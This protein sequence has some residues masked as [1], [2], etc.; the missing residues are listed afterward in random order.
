[1]KY[2]GHK[3]NLRKNKQNLGRSVLY[4]IAMEELV[5]NAEEVI[6]IKTINGRNDEKL[7]KLAV[8]VKDKEGEY[9]AH[10]I[11]RLTPPASNEGYL[12]KLVDFWWEEKK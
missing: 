9:I 11:V 3:Q 7:Y 5:E 4:R 8:R 6:E 1:M 12:W 2:R 10:A